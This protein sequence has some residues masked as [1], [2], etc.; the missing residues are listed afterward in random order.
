[1]SIIDSVIKGLQAKGVSVDN[2]N[3]IVEDPKRKNFWK[4]SSKPL[5]K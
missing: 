2:Y 3:S 4:K 5:V 1:M